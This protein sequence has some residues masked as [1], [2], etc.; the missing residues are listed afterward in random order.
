MH[1]SQQS[2]TLAL[3]LAA[4]PHKVTYCLLAD[5]PITFVVF[6][7]FPDSAVVESFGPFYRARFNISCTCQNQTFLITNTFQV[8]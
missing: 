8:S 1:E 6:F 3:S 5:T 4:A 7:Q 2:V